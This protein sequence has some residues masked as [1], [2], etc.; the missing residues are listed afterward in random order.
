MLSLREGKVLFYCAFIH[1]LLF[2]CTV[3][4]KTHL[5]GEIQWIKMYQGI[6]KYNAFLV[7]AKQQTGT[8][9]EFS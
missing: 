2:E 5:C 4:K 6:I 9:K 7:K 3:A 1:A 8:G